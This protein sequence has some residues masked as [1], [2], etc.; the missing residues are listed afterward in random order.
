[1]NRDFGL[2]WTAEV[3]SLFG[4]T[5]TATAVSVLA[6]TTFDATPGQIGLVTAAGSVPTIVFGLVSGVVADRLRRPRSVLM[7]CNAAGAAAVLALAA[8]VWQGAASV[9]WLAGLGLLLGTTGVL[10]APIYFTHLSGLLAP[11]GDTASRPAPG[12]LIRG[13]AKLQSGQYGARLTGHAAAGPVIALSAVLGLVAD[14]LSYLVSLV[15]LLSIRAPDRGVAQPA[16]RPGGSIARQVADGARTLWRPPFLRAMLPLFAVLSAASG[17]VATLTAPFLLRNL[18]VPVALYGLLFALTGVAGLAGSVVATR[19]VSRVTSTTL[20]LIGFSGAAVA[21]LF[22]PAAVGGLP[23]AATIAGIGIALPIF[24]GAMANIGL[25]GVI[26]IDIPE[27]FL[28]RVTATVQTL[29]IWGY[30]VGAVVGG[31]LGDRFGVRAALFASG[32]GALVCL[33]IVLPAARAADTSGAEAALGTSS[34]DVDS[35]TMTGPAHVTRPA[36][37]DA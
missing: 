12:D 24:F 2:Y 35:P 6:V 20:T 27:E 18:Q 5:F 26:T 33:L 7:A 10:T 8:G 16:D 32:L 29:V 13:R 14:A 31:L 37:T 9:W 15:L 30:L 22:L 17:A 21:L 28:G 3:T 1:M 23:I 4:S 25:T 19:L 36:R 34:S 11:R